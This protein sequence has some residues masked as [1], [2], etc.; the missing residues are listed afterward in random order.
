MKDLYLDLGE[1]VRARQKKIEL[2]H[3]TLETQIAII[4]HLEDI[5]LKICAMSGPYI[6]LND[7]TG[8]N[9]FTGYFDNNIIKNFR[10]MKIPYNEECLFDDNYYKLK[11][12]NFRIVVEDNI[13]CTSWH[14]VGINTKWSKD[15]IHQMTLIYQADKV[16][17]CNS[18]IQSILLPYHQKILSEITNI[19]YIRCPYH[20]QFC[21]NPIA[22]P[23]KFVPKEWLINDSEFCTLLPPPPPG[24]SL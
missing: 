3:L 8:T 13:V 4:E 24:L 23:K 22:Y 6:E 14:D 10:S 17:F 9:I 7:I 12:R 5:V 11:S 21:R 16:Q 2:E 15:G 19:V 18:S 20:P 1:M